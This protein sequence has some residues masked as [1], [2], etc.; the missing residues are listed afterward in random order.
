MV[1]LISL[2]LAEVFLLLCAKLLKTHPGWFYGAAA[3]ASAAVTGL[4]WA[5]PEGISPAILRAYPQI[6]NCGII[7]IKGGGKNGRKELQVMDN[8]RCVL[9]GHKG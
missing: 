7:A 3:L 5:A 1:L 2:I 6:S 9:G 4:Y 8:I